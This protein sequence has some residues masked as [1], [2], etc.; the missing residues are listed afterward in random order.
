MLSYKFTRPRS[1]VEYI[2]KQIDFVRRFN[3]IGGGAWNGKIKD[4]IGFIRGDIKVRDEIRVFIKTKLKENQENFCYYCG[5]SFDVFNNDDKCIHIDHILPKKAIHGRYGRFTFEPLNLILCC[6]VCNMTLKE[7]KDYGTASD[8]ETNYSGYDFTIIHPYLDDITAHL[9]VNRIGAVELINEDKSKG[10][11]MINEF[12]L[13][14]TYRVERR[15][16]SICARGM[17]VLLS[18]GMEDLVNRVL[19]ASSAR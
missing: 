3:D 6:Y 4:K 18:Q 11:F 5:E 13:N 19:D 17:S 10:D 1:P 12:N 16:S 2:E 7:D 8:D 14:D 15:F 9:E